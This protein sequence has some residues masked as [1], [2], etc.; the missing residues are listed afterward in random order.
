[1]LV[2]MKDIKDCMLLFNQLQKKKYHNVQVFDPDN[3]PRCIATKNEI[4]NG[5]AAAPNVILTTT[6]AA[7]GVNFF[8]TCYPLMT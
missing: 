2:F 3:V 7:I 5:A 4:A 1:M 6:E 8:G